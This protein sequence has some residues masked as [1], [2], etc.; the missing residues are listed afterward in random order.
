MDSDFRKQ[1]HGKDNLSKNWITLAPIVE[2]KDEEV[3]LYM[4][5]EELKY[6]NQYN[7]G[8]SR[9]GC[10]I[11][12][13][14]SDYTDL[15]IEKHYPK[16]WERWV[17][18][19]KQNYVIWHVEQHLKWTLDEWINGKWKQGKSVE[20]ELISGSPTIE[21]IKKLAEVKGISETMAKKYFNKKCSCGKRLNPTEIAMNYKQ[22][23][24]FEEVEDNRQL[25]CKKCFCEKEDI[26]GK[27]YTQR[28]IRYL[29]EGCNLF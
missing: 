23:G 24:R 13:Y 14:Q 27:E 22:Y 2:W 8:F 28:A 11:C 29:E 4:L 12:P 15:L 9:C 19:L 3:W 6:N 26:P 7:V 16:Q 20:N 5:R 10:L 1:I 25:L 18:V 17:R 21:R